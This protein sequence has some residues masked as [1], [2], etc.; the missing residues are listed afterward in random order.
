[1]WEHPPGFKIEYNGI[2]LL[3]GANIFCRI[4]HRN[5]T[6]NANSRGNKMT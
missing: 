2:T 4:A 6:T 5:M 1:M 3:D